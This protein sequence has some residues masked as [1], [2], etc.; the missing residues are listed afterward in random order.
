[1]TDLLI[2][3]ALSVLL[4]A[5]TLL[6]LWDVWGMCRG[7]LSG[8]SLEDSYVPC[9]LAAAPCW[10]GL[11]A[12]FAVLAVREWSDS[13]AKE[14]LAVLLGGAAVSFAGGLLLIRRS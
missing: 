8:G 11:A 2:G 5:L 1:M 3:V 14:V 6:A 9:R 4:G 12:I 7:Q 10:L 13:G